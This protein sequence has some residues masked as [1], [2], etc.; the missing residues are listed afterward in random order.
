M[1]EFQ[2]ICRYHDFFLFDS[3]KKKKNAATNFGFSLIVFFVAIYKVFGIL[4]EK[5]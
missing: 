5:V 3:K 2:L 1:I 4:C